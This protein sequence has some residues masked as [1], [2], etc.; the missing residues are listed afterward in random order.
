M[1]DV[2][3]PV[4]RLAAARTWA[5][6]LPRLR[7]VWV[8]ATLVATF[9]AN[10]C[11]PTAMIDLGWT[12]RSGEW[13]LANGALL[14]ADPFTSAPKLLP[15]VD[16]QWLA[17][18][19][20]YGLYTTGGL[21]LVI[22]GTALAA[23]LAYGLVLAAAAERGRRLRLACGLTLGA[24]ALG[25]TN[26]GARAQTLAYPLFGLFILALARYERLRR[27]RLLWALPP[28]MLL[29]ANL[30]GSWPLG[31]VLLACAVL[32]RAIEQRTARVD[33]ALLGALAGASAAA[34]LTPFGADLFQYLLRIGGS[35]VVREV[36]SEW[37]PT[38]LASGLGAPFF[39][40]LALLGVAALLSPARLSVGECL[41]LAVF[42]SLALSSGRAIT[43]WG[44]LL[45]PGLARLLAGLL[46]AAGPRRPAR[47]APA[48]NAAL[49]ALLLGLA[50]GSLPWLKGANPLVPDALRPLVRKEM[51]AAVA[52][53][54]RTAA[55]PGPLFNNG[56]WGGYFDW[57]V[58]PAHQA[59]VDGRVE[60]YPAWV[61]ADY[62]SI[63]YPSAEWEALLLRHG[64]QSLVLSK[65]QNAD[66]LA[67][68][69]A[70]PD[71]WRPT[72]EDAQAAVFV[73]AD[74]ADLVPGQ[75][76]ANAGPTP[77][78]A[79]ASVP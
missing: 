57:A 32:G 78:S 76:L 2:A 18:V 54:L 5:V 35:V 28:A 24:Y 63:T 17:Q 4:A 66:L 50:A 77:P 46:P 65:E 23:T 33:R 31:L 27:T 56:D 52:D 9:P 3:A 44:L 67:E 8:L 64:F 12:L 75:R 48:L 69:R 16:A 38:S 21:E 6:P 20:Y 30:H 43:W 74:G 72:Y 7:H 29:W 10:A 13:M 58:W 61:W 15:Q 49:S 45:A 11:T 79:G 39:G 41:A 51:P 1:T 40:S 37:T 22:A 36:V 60:L 55:V 42:G 70:R 26:L 59:W 71:A 47:E 14:R 34:L 19:V 68:V 25:F 62:V 73:R 53:Y